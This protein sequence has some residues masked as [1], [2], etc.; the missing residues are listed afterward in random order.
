[1]TYE[2]KERQRFISKLVSNARAIVSNQ[3]ALPLGVYKMNQILSWLEPFKKAEDIDLSIFKDYDL[4]MD[5]LPVGTER[6]KWNIEK[7][8]EFEK[9]F[10]E[11]N[12]IYKSDIL[13]KC[14][15]LIETYSILNSEES[16]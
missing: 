4:D 3:V 14:K 5:E 15:E 9:E 16:E 12:K 11:I 1:M 8:I 7:L 2:E 13:R 10:D 6:L